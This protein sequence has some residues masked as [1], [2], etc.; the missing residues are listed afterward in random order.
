MTKEKTQIGRAELN[1]APQKPIS[2]KLKDKAIKNKHLDDS[3]VDTRVIKDKAVTPEKLSD[4]V[5]GYLVIPITD[6]ID[7]KY[8]NITSEL[9]S[10][11]ESLQ[12][13]GI[14]LSNQFGDRTD[15]GI[16]QKTLTKALGKFWQEM[17]NI[18]GKD[19]MD[20]KLTVVPVTTYSETS[21]QIRITAD[22]SE[23]ISDFDSIKIYVDN[24]LI[25]ESSDLEVFTATHTISKT[26][27]VKAVGVIL[28][29]TVIKEQTILDELPFFIGSGSVYTDIMN[30][31]CRQT[32]EGTLEG[33]YDMQVKN[34]GEY[35]FIIIPASRK[36]EFRRADMN[37]YEIPMAAP[38]E[39]EDIVVYKSIS[40]Y[41]AGEY[42]ID[43]DINS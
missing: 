29:K 22:C 41:V 35:I 20:F 32:L 11:I 18:T 36:S 15:I 16:T 30:E 21:A 23:A 25:A 1:K 37:G 34:N 26:S 13:G 19:Y 3:S 2:F 38:V 9:Y 17:G 39:I 40:T 8:T 42:N 24:V 6:S 14:A 28:G 31:E 27:V 4:S 12:V 10:M 7:K 43:I 33:N 5:Q